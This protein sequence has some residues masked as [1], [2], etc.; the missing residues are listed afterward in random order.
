MKLSPTVLKEI[1]EVFTLSGQALSDRYYNLFGERPSLAKPDPVRKA[2]AFRLQER[3]Y[4][5]EA[6]PRVEA[7]VKQAREKRRARQFIE[8]SLSR[9][10]KAHIKLWNTLPL[11]C[12]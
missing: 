6:A 9:M 1:C 3:F 4:G 11:S 7:V 2:I 8:D 5:C 12:R 10:V